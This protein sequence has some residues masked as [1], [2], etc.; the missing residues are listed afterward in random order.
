MEKDVTTRHYK[1]ERTSLKEH[2]EENS[3]ILTHPTNGA[4]FRSCPIIKSGTV[5]NRQAA[6]DTL[7]WT[8]IINVIN[9]S[10]NEQEI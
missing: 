5:K 1:M 9:V 6:L 3:C 2:F 8:N 10:T 7:L 4:T